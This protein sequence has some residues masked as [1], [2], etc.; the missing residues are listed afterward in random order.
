MGL[1]G[2]LKP[3]G[4]E[5]RT[6]LA[7]TG[8]HVLGLDCASVP[9]NERIRKLGPD[10]SSFARRRRSSPISSIPNALWRRIWQ[11]AANPQNLRTAQMPVM[12]IPAFLILWRMLMPISTDGQ[13][14]GHAGVLQGA[15]IDAAH[16]GSRCTGRGSLACRPCRRRRPARRSP[17]G[18]RGLPG[19]GPRC[20]GRRPRRVRPRQAAGGPLRPRPARWAAARRARPSRPSGTTTVSSSLPASAASRPASVR[21][22]PL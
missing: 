3:P 15:G 18:D 14:F 22:W 4:Q 11:V 13:P 7:Q 9:W 16:A 19:G 10:P 21:S 17:R 5:G 8:S 1:A 20:S 6:W 2:E 12:R